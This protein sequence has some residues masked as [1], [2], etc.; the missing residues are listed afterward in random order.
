M[1]LKESEIRAFAQLGLDVSG[2]GYR[3]SFAALVHGGEVLWNERSR[4]KIYHRFAGGQQYGPLRPAESIHII[5]GGFDAGPVA[6]IRI[7]AVETSI[8]GRGFN[9]C[10]LDE[11]LQPIETASFDTCI[12]T[13]GTVV[14]LRPGQDRAGAGNR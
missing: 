11:N 5:S 3:E 9:L 8:N 4:K 7:G 2:L 13:N 12:G 1:K 6:S 14:S 10:I